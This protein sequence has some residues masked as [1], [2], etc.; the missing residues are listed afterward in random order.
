[1]FGG[2]GHD[3]RDANSIMLCHRGFEIK[4]FKILVFEVTVYSR[5]QST[6]EETMFEWS[7]SLSDKDVNLFFQSSKNMKSNFRRACLNTFGRPNSTSQPPVPDRP[8]RPTNIS[9]P[10]ITLPST[11]ETHRTEMTSRQ[12]STVGI[13]MEQKMCFYME[14]LSVEET[15]LLD[16]SSLWLL[17]SR[18]HKC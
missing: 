11:S 5:S 16:F 4:L 12:R 6:I 9:E 17:E 14:S 10:G 1:M 3:Y 7:H 18:L 13:R 8:S 2:G 15:N